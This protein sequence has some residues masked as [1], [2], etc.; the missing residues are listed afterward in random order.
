MAVQYAKERFAVPTLAPIVYNLGIIAGGLLLRFDGQASPEG[1][2]WG[3]LGGAVVGNFLIQAAGARAAGLRWVP[4]GEERGP[5]LRE[6]LALALPLMVAQSLV[7]LDEQLGRSFGSLA[8]E[9]SISWLQFARRTMLVPVGVIAQ[10]A[11][12]A[13][14]PFLARLAAEGRPAELGRVLGKALRSVVVLSVGAA[15]ALAA[16]ALPVIRVLYERGDWTAPDTAATVAPLVLFSL[17]IPMWG[18][19]QLYARAFYAR[20]QMW[21]PAVV[22]SVAT[23]AAL[24]L[25]RV[26]LDAYGVAGLAQASTIALTAYTAVLA[27]LWHRATGFTELVRLGRTLGRS[28]WLGAVAGLAAWG[29]STMVLRA[30]GSGAVAATGALLAGGVAFL[31]SLYLALTAVQWA[32]DRVAAAE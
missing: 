9:G 26:L 17:A 30:S 31:I 19:Q 6:Y 20:R 16:L 25:Y 24:P 22:G 13:A 11:G 29:A 32:G 5:I 21:T 7:V 3:A 2:A 12:V 23:V 8:A 27:Y 1:F 15:S 10:A 14:Y 4:P 18:A 28:L